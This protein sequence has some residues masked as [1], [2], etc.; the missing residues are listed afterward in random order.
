METRR[1]AE[2][3]EAFARALRQDPRNATLHLELGLAR[4]ELG[5]FAAG[6][7]N[8]RRAVELDS[9]RAR[10]FVALGLTQAKTGAFDSA[11]RSLRRAAALEPHF[12]QLGVYQDQVREMRSQG[13]DP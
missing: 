13:S 7:V 3:A 4:Y 8:L 2:A 12:P 5:Q 9:T 10:T 11:E 1:H 6:L